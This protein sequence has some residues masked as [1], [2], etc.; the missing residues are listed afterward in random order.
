MLF[1]AGAP[2]AASV[3]M[4]KYVVLEKAVGE[5]PLETLE[6]FRA[7][8]SNLTGVPL[9]YAGRLDPMASGKLLVLIGEECKRQDTYHGLD[10]AYDIEVL[11][12]VS[13]D[14]GDVLGIIDE[15]PR[16]SIIDTDWSTV[17]ASFVGAITLPYP[18]YSARTVQG[19]PLHT[20]AV[21]GR[22][23]EIAIPHKTSTIHVLAHTGKRT[24]TRTDLHRDATKKIA[25]LPTVTS[26]RKALGNDFRRPEVYMSWEHLQTTGNPNDLFTILSFTCVCSSGT[27]MRTLADELAKKANTRGLA[28]S[29]HRTHIGLFKNDN[30]V[31]E[32]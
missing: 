20:W 26:E 25:L 32:F 30:W 7:S 3:P 13:S 27:Y 31:N 21:T 24:I 10:K 11:L 9:S 22:I 28:Y 17:A 18:Q 8:H 29:I 15:Q 14:S 5:T 16:D 6:R 4:E 2:L 12:E 23:H 19:I 1:W